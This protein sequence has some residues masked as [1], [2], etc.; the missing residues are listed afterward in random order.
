M[1]L[2]KNGQGKTN[3]LE[4]ISCLGLTKS[5]YAANDGTLVQLGQDAFVVEGTFA[6]ESEAEHHV[7]L[8]YVRD[9]PLKAYT[10]DGERLERLS[11]VI[12]MFPLVVL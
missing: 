4:A 2:G 12:G 3:M 8:S 7:S 1:L 9:P 6:S 11:S 10:V 5:F